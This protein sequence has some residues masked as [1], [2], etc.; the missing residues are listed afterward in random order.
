M[1][2]IERGTKISDDP[3]KDLVRFKQGEEK[4]EEENIPLP[5]KKGILKN[6]LEEIKKI[7]KKILS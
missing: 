1:A 6:V 3:A 7:S 4:P 2:K 5:E